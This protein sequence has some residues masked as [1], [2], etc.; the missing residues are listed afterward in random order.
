MGMMS[1]ADVKE[2]ADKRVLDIPVQP[3]ETSW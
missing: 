3:V 1:H 2:I